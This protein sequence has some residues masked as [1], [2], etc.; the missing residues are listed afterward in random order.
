MKKV[1]IKFTCS[2]CKQSIILEVKRQPID[3]DILASYIGYIIC[4]EC[5]IGKLSNKE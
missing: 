3:I 4:D 5:N 1:K 2:I